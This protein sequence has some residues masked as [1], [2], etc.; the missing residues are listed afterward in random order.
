V[1]VAKRAAQQAQVAHHR[2]WPGEPFFAR[3]GM[4][5][6]SSVPFFVFTTFSPIALNRPDPKLL[7][8]ISA[9][10]TK[11]AFKHPRPDALIM[12]TLNSQLSKSTRN[13]N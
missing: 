2:E 12:S 3:R 5:G 8:Q 7:D 9:A 10:G 4:I 6:R 11:R 13:T 1:D